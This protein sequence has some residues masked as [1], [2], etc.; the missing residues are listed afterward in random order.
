MANQKI[1]ELLGDQAAYYLEHQSRTIDKSM[2]HAPGADFV[3]R[4]WQGSNRNPQTLRSLQQ[5]FG[6]GRL[7]HTGYLSILPVDQA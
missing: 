6:S 4:I 2:L 1:R 5:L 7:A 3:D